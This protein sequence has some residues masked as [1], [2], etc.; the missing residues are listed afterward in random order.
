MKPQ[1]SLI[2]NLICVLLLFWVVGFFAIEDIDYFN[3]WGSADLQVLR[4][5]ALP[6][7][8]VTIILCINITTSIFG[9]RNP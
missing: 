9:K 8:L 7:L 4:V 5:I 6:N 3:P 2:L 1:T